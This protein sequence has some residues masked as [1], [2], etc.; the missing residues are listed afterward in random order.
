MCTQGTWTLISHPTQPLSTDV[1]A[2]KHPRVY[3]RHMNV[4]IPPHPT[5]PP[6]WKSCTTT[7]AVLHPLA[8]KTCTDQP[9]SQQLQLQLQLPRHDTTLHKLQL[10]YT[11]LHYSDITLLHDTTLITP[12]QLQLQ[13]LHYTNYT[14]PQLQPHYTTTTTTAALHHTTSSSCGWGD[15]PGDHCNHCSHFKK[16]NSN[17][18]SVH[19]WIHS[20]NSWFATTKLS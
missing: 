4:N 11:T 1:A 12:P 8:R 9:Y 2:A 6:Y 16:H 20:A 19:Q 17:H 7:R 15:R 3:A 13:L 14:T 5:R 10:D 18:L